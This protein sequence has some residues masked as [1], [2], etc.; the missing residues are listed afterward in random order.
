MSTGRKIINALAKDTRMCFDTR[1]FKRGG[2]DPQDSLLYLE[3]LMGVI[4]AGVQDDS[5]SA[6]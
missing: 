4:E 1:A 5:R 3:Q 2:P 6:E